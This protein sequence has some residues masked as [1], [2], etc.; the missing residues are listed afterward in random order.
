MDFF[1]RCMF[2]REMISLLLSMRKKPIWTCQKVVC[3]P[4]SLA[5]TSLT[6]RILQRNCFREKIPMRLCAFDDFQM[7]FGRQITVWVMPAPS[8]GAMPN[9]V[10]AISGALS[11]KSRGS[12]L[13]P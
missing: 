8:A 1:A 7:H 6:Q 2:G 11:E 5:A 4:L 13:V 10:T 12:L 3:L 9:C